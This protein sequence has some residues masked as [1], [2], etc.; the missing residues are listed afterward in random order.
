[1]KKR[2]AII[3]VAWIGVSILIGFLFG[4]IKKPIELPSPRFRETEWTEWAFGERDIMIHEIDEKWNE[5]HGD[6]FTLKGTDNVDEAIRRIEEAYRA[7]F[8]QEDDVAGSVMLTTY[9]KEENDN[10][11]ILEYNSFDDPL[12][13]AITIDRYYV[14]DVKRTRGKLII[15]LDK[16]TSYPKG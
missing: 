14:K 15:E 5:R 6:L 13:C 12:P 4:H 2:I 11:V 8:W 10:V 3:I 16:K 7:D 1:M 9:S